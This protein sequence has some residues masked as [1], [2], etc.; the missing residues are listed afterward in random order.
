MTLNFINLT[1][2][3]C[4]VFF[5]E[6]SLITSVHLVVR[7]YIL[8]YLSV[9]VCTDGNC[10]IFWFLLVNLKKYIFILKSL[11][12]CRVLIAARAFSLA[13]LGGG[14]SGCS[15]QA[16]HC[17]GFSCCRAWALGVQPSVIAAHGLSSRGSQDLE[18]R[19]SSRPI[20]LVALWHVGSSWTRDWTHVSCTGRGFFTTEPPGE[21][22]TY[23]FVQ[24]SHF[25]VSSVSLIR[26][27][28]GF[29]D[30]VKYK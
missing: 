14:Y 26:L 4:K 15:V 2:S 13:V 27:N 23:E 12:P 11:W 25:H 3:K 8:I 6:C 28:I 29:F 9:S 18:H 19:L 7:I 16:L 30:K 22:S 24:F 17:C 21:P 5:R 20:G 10:L 1:H